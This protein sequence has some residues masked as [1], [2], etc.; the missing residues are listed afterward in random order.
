MVCM[1]VEGL[2][3]KEPENASAIGFSNSLWDFVQRCWSGN[4]E[5]RPQVVDLVVHLGRAA[6]E[7]NRPM[8][9]HIEVE[10][11]TSIPRDLSYNCEEHRKLEGFTF[12]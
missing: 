4:M 2:R 12:L 6:R 5:L 10:G 8:P 7:W 11:I 1:V 3:P 9:P